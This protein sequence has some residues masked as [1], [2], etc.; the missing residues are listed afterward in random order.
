MTEKTEK[1]K[2]KAIRLEEHLETFEI[3]HPEIKIIRNR[4]GKIRDVQFPH[5]AIGYFVMF[6]AYEVMSIDY[7]SSFGERFQ[8]PS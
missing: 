1:W 3:E 6:N 8:F 2:K 5:D 4:H 7:I